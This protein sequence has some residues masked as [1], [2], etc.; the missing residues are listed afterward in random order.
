MGLDDVLGDGQ[1]QAG[2]LA[3]AGP[4]RPE[5]A[6][7]DP[8]QVLRGDAHARV[9]H[10][11]HHS[12]RL[13]LPGRGGLDV[14]ADPD[15]PTG[16]GEL[17]GVVHQV[18]DHLLG[19]L[20]VRQDPG[21]AGWQVHH[22]GD[23]CPGRLGLEPLHRPQDDFTHR[24]G[25][26]VEGHLPGLDAG[27]LQ[28]LLHHLGQGVHLRLDPVQEA[29]GRGWIRQGAVPQ[30]LHQGP[31]R[32]QGRAQ[33]VG[34]VA[35]EVL[36]DALQLPPLAQIP[37]DHQ[38]ALA[39]AVP[40]GG[41]R[42]PQGP[43][44]VHLQELALELVL[45]LA[46]LQQ[47]HHAVIP[48]HLG[49]G[50]ADRHRPGQPEQAGEGRVGPLHPPRLVQDQD[51][52]LQVV[53][54]RGHA[55]FLLGQPVH[56]PL[57]DGHQPVEGQAELGDLVP[58]RGGGGLALVLDQLFSHAGQAA[59]GAGQAFGQDGGQGQGG[60]EGQ[61]APGQAQ[62]DQGADGAIQ[63]GD[64]LGVDVLDGE[65][66]ELA[67]GQEGEAEGKEAGQEEEGEGDAPADG[68]ER[69]HLGCCSL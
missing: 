58:G 22:Q 11:D 63:L 31:E 7:E 27:E 53:Q 32:G 51:A 28:Q 42:H 3:G 10:L 68:S 52:V 46:L 66:L 39:E 44:I 9:R 23:T 36:A 62:E 48:H 6:L 13:T 15:L 49:E 33:L 25:G 5:E 61:G 4:I 60:Q 56:A 17:D 40:E 38:V 21:Q 41:H 47:L 64:Q 14:G 50:S 1:A 2:A 55:T 19:A 43:A 69:V 35:D 57:R 18:G 24:G 45:L 20:L 54:D 26:P 37:Q 67:D 30:G 59:E 34:D 65:G 8:G 29:L 16:W 12:R